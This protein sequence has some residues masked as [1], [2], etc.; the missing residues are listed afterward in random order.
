MTLI[1]SNFLS[2]LSHLRLAIPVIVG[3]SALVVLVNEATY[4]DT[5]ATLRGGIAL[6]DARI[7]T[8]RVLQLLTDAETAQRGY[9]LK[10]TG[11]Y[12][13]AL[14]AAKREL[15]AARRSLANFLAS[16]GQQGRA[17]ADRLEKEIDEM[18]VELDRTI[19]LVD[20]GD[21]QRS[22]EVVDTD[23]GTGNMDAIR[24]QL[25]S[26]L[27]VG[28]LMQQK[29]RVSLFD[30]LF[31]NRIA[32]SLLTMFSAIGAIA[33]IRRARQYDRERAGRQQE[34]ETEVNLRTTELRELSVHLQTA[35][36]DEK[37]S[38]AR[39][40][41]DELGGLLTAV[42]LDLARIRVKVAHDAAVVERLEQA[43]KRLNEGIALKRRVIE[44]LR[45]SALTNLGLAASLRILCSE[46]SAGLGIPI[47]ADIEEFSADPD[48]DLTI[49]RV[50]QESLTNISKY[51]LADEVRVRLATC[52]ETVRLEI[53]DDGAGFDLDQSPV[54]KHGI[55]G[56]RF[57]VASLGGSL[58][59]DSAPGR[60]TAVVAT[61]PLQSIADR[62]VLAD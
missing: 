11:D 3:V 21:R 7:D 40:L 43:N 23:L 14:N 61:F 6:T 8:A 53:T 30:A 19:A 33:Y 9:L 28:A 15:P 29:A 41:H 39:E 54:G 31:I 38:L 35:R 26:S 12:L 58:A 27:A 37:A 10:G 46:T 22:V 18:L 20:A 60:G 1:P 51:A 36:E 50:L 48:T 2:R 16:N 13:Q 57:R 5:T 34:L 52:G 55:V 25:Y 59:I 62:A 49:Y 32:L 42:K 17:T 44:T 4:S 45:P 24:Q 56:M 47:S